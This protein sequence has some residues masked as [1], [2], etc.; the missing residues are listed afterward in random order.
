MK[1]RTI[2][3]GIIFKSPKDIEQIKQISEFN[4]KAKSSFEQNGYEVQTTRIATNSWEEYVSSSSKDEIVSEIQKIE[5][6][7]L[8]Q[9]VSFLNIGYAQLPENILL[10]SDI[11]KNTSVISCSGKL[12]DVESGINFEKVKASA[13]TI[14][15]ISEQTENGIGN[16]RFCAWCN[17]KP[18]IPFFPVAYHEEETSFS[19]GVECS[20]LAMKAFSRS[21]NLME[22]EQ[23]LGL[24]FEEELKK[25]QE[26][27]ERISENHRIKFAGIDTSLAPSLDKN[28]SIAFAYE[29]LGMGKFGHPGT[30]T[31]SAMITRVLKNLSVKKCGY[32]GLMLPICEDFGLAQRAN[33]RTYNLTNLLLYSAVCGC[34][35]DTIPLPGD[36]SVEKI[37]AILLDVAALAIKLNKPLS[38]R[39]LP[40][41]GKKAGVMT[42]FNS[43]YL[44]DCKILDA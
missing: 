31:I 44:I 18:G 42:S 19:F 12:G 35:L 39:L 5:Q 41:P 9:D 20:D 16:F 28:E 38:A 34:G 10:S 7:C 14:K 4:R 26:I 13:E 8:S 23:N 33:E 40:V 32:S 6:A 21:K 37:E 25:I 24:I 17:C 1:I 15:R 11:I 43:P 3:T 29:K 22:A 27:A 30:L 2:T 36:I